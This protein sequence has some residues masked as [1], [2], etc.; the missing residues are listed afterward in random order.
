MEFNLYENPDSTP[1]IIE[2]S[3]TDEFHKR[4][5]HL[6]WDSGKNLWTAAN[7]G[8]GAGEEPEA[9]SL[10]LETAVRIVN[11]IDKFLN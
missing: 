8:H 2:I 9:S 4:K 5:K 10:L 11:E 6:L 3:Q 7:D 1:A